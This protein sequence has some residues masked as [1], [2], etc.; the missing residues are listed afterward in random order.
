MKVLRWKRL[1]ELMN[2]LANT[3]RNL[4]VLLTVGVA[5]IAWSVSLAQKPEIV[6]QTGHTGPVNSLTF[7]A[8]GRL[9]A[10]GSERDYA[11]KLWETATGLE[12]RTLQGYSGSVA[13]S[14][15]AKVVASGVSGTVKLWDVVT[16][17]L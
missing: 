14:P 11:V 6:V 13:F 5:L 3:V 15:D 10:S 2:S 17:R 4:K 16:G 8:D 12:L 7:S 1:V 9:L